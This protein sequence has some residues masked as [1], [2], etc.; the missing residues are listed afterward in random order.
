VSKAYGSG[1]LYTSCSKGGS[2]DQNCVMHGEAWLNNSRASSA[3]RT[4]K[5]L[6]PDCRSHSVESSLVYWL[7][8]NKQSPWSAPHAPFAVLCFLCVLHNSTPT[9]PRYK[10]VYSSPCWREYAFSWPRGPF[11]SASLVSAINLFP[12]ISRPSSSGALPSLSPPSSR[13]GQLTRDSEPG[14]VQTLCLQRVSN[15]PLAGD[16]KRQQGPNGITSWTS[17]KHPCS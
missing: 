1:V 14:Q 15:A 7:R 10:H 13:V 17:H 4:G 3:M 2:P 9:T 8:H 12:I 16:N 11:D 6:T 5:C